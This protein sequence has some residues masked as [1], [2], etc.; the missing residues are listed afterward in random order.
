MQPNIVE[1][2][3]LPELPQPGPIELWLYEQPLLPAAVLILIALA[4]L[5]ALRRSSHFK[6]VGIPIALV[7]SLLAAAIYVVGMS[8]VTDRELLKLKSVDL[9]QHV[10]NNES[11]ELR[12]LLDE[13]ARLN[14]RFASAEGAERI[15]SLAST[16]NRG[17]VE[18][19]EV[20]EINAGLYG[21]QVATTQIRVSTEGNMFPTLSWWRI[22]WTRPSETSDQWLVTH[23]EPIWI[24][25]FTNPAGDQ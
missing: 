22:D 9:V 18:T 14:T 5:F 4:T 13:N 16:R 7:A 10:A 24:R 8:T 21:P 23:I 3:T 19:A 17:I 25:G 1:P 20:S 2:S 11:M 6:R 15:V 12:S